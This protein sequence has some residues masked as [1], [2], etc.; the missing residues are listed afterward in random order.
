MTGLRQPSGVGVRERSPARL[1]ER[2]S[3]VAVLLFAGLLAI[4]L[5]TATYTVAQVNDTR[6]SALSAWHLGAHGSLELPSEW[7]TDGERYWMVE[8]RDGGH[9]TNRFPG[10]S[11]WAAPFYW[12]AQQVRPQPVP[13][14]PMLID[15]APA[16]VAAA[17]ASALA[18]ALTFLVFRRLVDRR[19]ALAAALL[20][21]LGSAVW[22]V[23]ADALWT[24]G[25]THLWIVLGL[26][27]FQGGRFAASGAAFALSVITRPQT[28]VVAAVLGVGESL[29]QRS[30]RPALLIGAT[31]S[32]GVLAMVGY[33]RWAFGTWTPIAGYGTYGVDNL[34]GQEWTTFLYGV[35][36]TVF[37]PGR[38]LVFYAPVLV[39][40]LPGLR[41]GWRASPPWVR[42]AALS[43]VTYM[44]VQLR[45]NAFAG[46]TNFFGS[47][48]TIEMLVLLSPLLVITWDT[49]A[50]HSRSLRAII[51]VTSIYM[52]AL[53]ALGASIPTM[54]RSAEIYE[55]WRKAII[56]YCD[57]DP[58]P[59][60]C[61]GVRLP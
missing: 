54:S 18:V 9:F 8:G 2:D 60:G 5:S 13:A 35:A 7:P 24:H 56:E 51:V 37:D 15:Y 50:R 29:R 21:G 4:Y 58:P 3:I 32:L 20:L 12:V 45:A 52:V 11:L 44:L 55:G 48:L 47:R 23:S 43:G 27:A 46:G 41:A 30:L 39:V 33:S 61:E 25:L 19:T 28:A 17:T 49:W 31:S 10:A 1:L 59:I 36:A 38:G 6:A 42:L 22:A 14:D 57:D 53:H 16:A 40:L 34:T 26:L